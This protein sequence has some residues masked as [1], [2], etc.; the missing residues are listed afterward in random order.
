MHFL[1]PT[2][3]ESDTV[4]KKVEDIFLL[5][6]ETLRQKVLEIGKSCGRWDFQ[7]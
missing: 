1:P 5:H 3:I 6:K 2:V 4:D 7:F